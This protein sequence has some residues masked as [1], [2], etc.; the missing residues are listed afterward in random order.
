M[1]S[2]TFDLY[3]RTNRATALTFTLAGTVGAY[4]YFRQANVALRGSH[5]LP[6]LLTYVPLYIVAYSAFVNKAEDAK[7]R[8]SYFG[9]AHN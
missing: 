5:V 6:A 1:S 7:F 2:E 9:G 8:G 4:L 3:R